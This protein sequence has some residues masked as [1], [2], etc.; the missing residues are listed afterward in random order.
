MKW[1]LMTWTESTTSPVRVMNMA[2]MCVHTVEHLATVA[3]QALI[4]RSAVV[5]CRKSHA[6]QGNK[7]ST[8]TT[9]VE[10]EDKY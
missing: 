3:K 9:G 5:C 7:P 2:L 6:K 8:T 4:R 10:F 1:F